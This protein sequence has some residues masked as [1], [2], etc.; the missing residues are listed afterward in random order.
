MVKEIYFSLSFL[1]PCWKSSAISGVLPAPGGWT[2]SSEDMQILIGV[3]VVRP[4]P[5]RPRVQRKY[6][7]L[8]VL[9]SHSAFQLCMRETWPSP[10]WRHRLIPSYWHFIWMLCVQPRK[11]T[12]VF[13]LNHPDISKS[14]CCSDHPLPVFSQVCSLTG[15]VGGLAG[16]L[17]REPDNTPSQVSHHS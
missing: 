16:T 12:E 14:L 9:T 2:P 13:M 4:I 15:T 11:H 6:C 5:G 1:L 8:S 10:A 3:M 7:F 17:P